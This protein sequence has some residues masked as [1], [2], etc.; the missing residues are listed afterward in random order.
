[1]GG[2]TSTGRR[3]RAG[4]SRRRAGRNARGRRQRKQ[5]RAAAVGK[6]RGAAGVLALR[7]SRARPD[8]ETHAPQ[9]TDHPSPDPGSPPRAPAGP[10]AVMAA[11]GRRL[12]AAG[13]A[14]AALALAGC[15][16]SAHAPSAASGGGP[17]AWLGR[18]RGAHGLAARRPA[19]RRLAGPAARVGADARRPRDRLVRSPLPGRPDHRLPERDPEVGA[20]DAAGLGPLP[21][22]AQR[23]GGRPA[24][25]ARSPPPTGCAR[26]RPEDRA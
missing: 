21:R 15:A 5:R 16:G 3:R 13:A 22:R 10:A 6:E 26:A 12:A 20:R 9:P 8:K 24:T 7:R 11:R 19:R 4:P 2:R 1:M 14:A 17:F 23:P 18:R 25:C